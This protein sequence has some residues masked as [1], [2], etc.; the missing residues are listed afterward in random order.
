MTSV[1]KYLAAPAVI[2][3]LVS[4]AMSCSSSSS[5][6]GGTL[7]SYDHVSGRKYFAVRSAGAGRASGVRD[8]FP[9]H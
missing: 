8:P 6:S 2:V 4:P 3:L 9:T 5:A 1:K 7:M